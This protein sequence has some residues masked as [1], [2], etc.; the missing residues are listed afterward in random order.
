MTSKRATLA[1]FANWLSRNVDH[2]VIDRTH[3]T[4]FFTIQLEW[5]REGDGQSIFSAVQDQLGLA[6]QASKAPID[7]L[8]VD[9]AEKTPTAN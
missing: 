8:V 3:L 7:I 5:A 9:Q 2:P 6:L 4:G 1:G